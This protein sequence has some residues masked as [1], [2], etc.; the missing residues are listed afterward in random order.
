MMKKFPIVYH[1]RYNLSF[2]GLEKLQPLD[3]RKYERVYMDLLQRGIIGSADKVHR[4]VLPCWEFQ[5]ELMSSKYQFLLN[6]TAYICKCL[7]APF[8]LIP[9]FLLRLKVLDPMLLTTQGSV[10][11]ACLALKHGWAINLAGGFHH[12]NRSSGE[13]GCIYPDITFMVHYMRKWHAV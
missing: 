9:E 13:G 8:Y 7:E 4:P 6:Y 12:S 1:E 2:F 5:N 10:D 11:A 3:S